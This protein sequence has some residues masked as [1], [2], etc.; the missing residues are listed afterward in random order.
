VS[1]KDQ[2]IEFERLIAFVEGRMGAAERAAVEQHLEH[3]ARCADDSAWL[4]RFARPF[5]SRDLEP[6]PA[7]ARERVRAL[8]RAWRKPPARTT[9]ALLRFDS[10]A[11]PNAIGRRGGAE[12]ERQLIFAAASFDL[13][14]RIARQDDRWVVAGQVLGPETAGYVEIAAA[15]RSERVALS[16]SCEFT[17]PPL[18]DGRYTLFLRLGDLEVRIDDLALPAE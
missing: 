5:S 12:D 10:F 9:R 8:F 16:D 7:G 13:D 18:E 11:A 15:E 6:P 4:R 14:L 3:C 2:H 1:T 17:L